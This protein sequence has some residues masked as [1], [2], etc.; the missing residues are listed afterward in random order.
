MNKSAIPIGLPALELAAALTSQQWTDLERFAEKRL[1][2]SACTPQRQRVLAF[3]SGRTI[4]HTAVEQ[5][6]LGDLDSPGGRKLRR[7]QRTGPAPFLDA[8]RGAINSSIANAFACTEF[9]HE[10]MPIGAEAVEP[11]VYE[12]RSQTSLGEQL[13]LRDLERILFS[14]LKAEAGDDQRRQAAVHALRDD[15]VTG[16]ARGKAGQGVDMSVKNEVRQQ[17]Q[18]IWNEL[19]LG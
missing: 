2:R 4:V 19:N 16:H 5:F 9:S 17:A 11:D 1:R 13:D 18:E 15:C 12:P 10:H 14:Q 6:A 3:L 8:L 7:R